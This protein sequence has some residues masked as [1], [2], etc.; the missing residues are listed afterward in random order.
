MA[1]SNSP[2]GLRAVRTMNGMPLSG[3][4]RPYYVPSDYAVNLFVGDPVVIVGDS[5]DNEI[6][7]FPPG[8][9][10]EVNIASAGD[11]QPITG[12]IVGFENLTGRDQAT[13]GAASTERIAQVIDY[14]GVVFEIRDDGTGTPTVDWVGW[15]AV[16]KAGAG[17]TYTGLSGWTMDG[18][19]TTAPSADASNQLYIYALAPKLGNEVGDYGIWEV[20]IN[21][22]SYAPANGLGVA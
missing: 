21:Q 17:S 19:G 8:G 14:N 18:G 4:I 11:G 9:L 10:S 15:N 20:L 2:F 1:N 22:N 3:M 5:N 16:L 7:G 12:V 6:M 13:Y